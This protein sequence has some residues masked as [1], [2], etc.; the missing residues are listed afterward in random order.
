MATRE[1]IH[2]DTVIVTSIP[3]GSPRHPTYEGGTTIIST[4]SAAKPRPSSK[5]T[6]VDHQQFL[7]D[8]KDHWLIVL[9][10]T[11]KKLKA[12]KSGIG[13][14]S[15]PM[16]WWQDLLDKTSERKP[17]IRKLSLLMDGV[18]LYETTV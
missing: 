8:N 12:N 17:D 4:P 2:P 5:P 16:S 10:T 14:N 13:L 3:K 7:E 18:S 9:L 6:D 1:T 15:T 11:S